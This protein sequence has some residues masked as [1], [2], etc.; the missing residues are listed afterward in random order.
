M[1]QSLPAPKRR[2]SYLA[3]FTLPL[4]ISIYPALFN[5]ANNA[6]VLQLSSLCVLLFIL[7][8][9]AIF[10]FLIMLFV[11]KR[12]KYKSAIAASV[13]LILFHSYGIVYDKLIEVDIIQV[14]HFTLFVI[15]FA[16]GYYVILALSIIKDNHDEKIW[17]ML[18]I[19][20]VI[21]LLYNVIKIVPVEITKK[22]ALNKPAGLI[23][24]EIQTIG[25]A[26]YPDIYYIVFDEMVGFEAMRQYWNNNNID[27]FVS[28]LVSE[29]FYIAEHS[30]ASTLNTYHELAN[31][32]N[33]E[34]Y[35]YDPTDFQKY[36]NED[37]NSISRNKTMEYLKT[38]G[39]NIVVFD[40]GLPAATEFNADI[41]Y[42]TSINEMMSWG[43]LFDDFG[44]LVLGNT[45]L[46]PFIINSMDHKNTLTSH[47]KMLIFSM[48]N[49]T[50]PDVPSPKLVYIHL[51]IPHMPFLFDQ[52]SVRNDLEDQNDWNLYEGYYVFA[53]KYAKKMIK[54]ILLAYNHNDSPVI[55]FQSDHGAR[56]IK[57][58][59]NNVILEN[60]PSNY[61]YLIVNTLYLPN[62]PN[63]PLYD[64]LDPINTFPIIFNCYFNSEIPLIK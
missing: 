30:Q 42:R 7:T 57:L 59:S 12:Q 29:G 22:Q 3:K 60:Y 47:E 27:E 64:D 2:P 24:T 41:V 61:Q 48:N 38:L 35:P 46:N 51:L 5:Y 14:E 50:T 58:E 11:F 20:T 44:K 4:G 25:T 40:E 16:L 6:I 37:L 31:R 33:Y 43:A 10:V 19:I 36:W 9:I 45:L 52:D 63:V 62:C 21:L 54:N 1:D 56:N 49:V 15:Y 32:L 39:Y 17:R 34:N 8:G 55:I 18:T 23:E 13:I 26:S 28:Y 53:T